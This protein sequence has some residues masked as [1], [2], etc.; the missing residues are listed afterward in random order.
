[1]ER[2][3]ETILVCWKP[4]CEEWVKLNTDGACKLCGSAGCGG[5][6][7][8]S[9]GLYAGGLGFLC[10][11]V[12]VDSSVVVHVLLK[13]GSGRPRGCA[14]VWK[15]HRLMELD[16]KVVIHH[17][18]REL[19]KCADVLANFGCNMESTSVLYENCL[20]HLSELF[21]AGI[22]EINTSRVIAS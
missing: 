21:L 4:P 17:A 5:V 13:G 18:Y 14:L 11:E 3:P 15:I 22:M 1:M 10:V 12:N 7:R 19:N 9:D 2:R 20:L 8:G 16:W 6:I